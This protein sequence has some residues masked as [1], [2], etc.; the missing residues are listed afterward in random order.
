MATT[1]NYSFS[2]YSSTDTDVRFLDFRVATAGSQSTSNFYVIDTVLKQH[3]D[4]IDSIN[5]T[6]SAFVV[7][8]TYSSGSLYT[9]SVANYP[10]YK[11]EQLIVLSLNQKNTGAV[12]ININGTT[13]KD[14]M[15]Y[16]SDGVLKA[17]EAGDF[18]AN[19]PVLCLYDG[20]RFVVIGITSASSITVTGEAGDILQIADDGT[21]ESSG[22]KAAQPNGIATLDENGN[23]VQVA[24]MANSAAAVYSGEPVTVEY[25]DENRI[26]SVAVYGNN[27]QTSGTTTAPISMN[28]VDSIQVSGNNLFINNTETETKSG[29]TFTV[30]PNK[31]VTVNGTNSTS[32]SAV[33][34][35]GYNVSLPAGSYTL[36]GTSSL[37]GGAEIEIKIKRVSGAIE[38]FS[39]NNSLHTRTFN[40]ATG[41]IIDTFYVLVRAGQTADNVTVYP[42][43]NVGSTALPYEPYNGNITQLPI[44]REL[45]RIGEAA[46]K[47]ITRVKSVYDKRVVLD[48]SSDEVFIQANI[49]DGWIQIAT[50]SDAVIPE[51]LDIVGSIKSSYLN[52]YAID[53]I[54]LKKCSG[55]SVDSNRR[56][57]LSFKTSEY[58]DVTSVETAKTYLSAH[59][60][61]VYYQSTAYDGSNGL[62]VCLTEYQTGFVELDGETL[63]FTSATYNNTYW[64]L[65]SYSAPGIASNPHINSHFPS[66]VFE[67]NVKYSFIFSTK[68]KMEPYF[69]TVEALNAYLAAQKAAG[70]PVQIPYQLAT[71]EV[72][73]TDPVDF[74]NAAGPLTVVTGGQV[75]V[76]M[77]DFVT[78]RTPAFLNKLDKTGDGSDVTVTFTG[79]ATDTDIASGDKLSILFGKILKR[80]TNILNG[81]TKVG[82]ATKADTDNLGNQITGTYANSLGVANNTIVL[83][84]K[85][86][87][88]LSTI[89]VPYAN[90]AGNVAT[91]IKEMGIAVQTASPY[92]WF[93]NYTGS[94]NKDGARKYYASVYADNATYSTSAGRSN[95]IVI[96]N[97]NWS[98]TDGS[99]SAVYANAE[100][101]Y[102]NLS[103]SN[104]AGTAWPNI[105]VQ[106]INGHALNMA[107]NGTSLSITW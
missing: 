19:S 105:S 72:Y 6:P 107:L 16:G 41:D 67:S 68:T 44:P 25:V 91:S 60:L 79:A 43:L 78:D 28:G 31:S 14:V 71:P 90:S 24:N 15:K 61:T 18:V 34:Y 30:N 103:S 86:G 9:A 70:T 84:N 40:I 48:G 26:G 36:S 75:E 57:R 38:W 5:A 10:G 54:Y 17:V 21:I 74:D 49:I 3:S 35:T 62:D 65:P 96:Y 46:D 92:A 1:P 2:V 42:M 99:I 45:H 20:T 85:I 106:R 11:N 81:T 89:T 73:A 22:K 59:P 58:P 55:I 76:K 82:Y 13:N 63:A 100:K 77:T 47:C 32:A 33:H 7:K 98:G 80:F 97:N 94:G 50:E 102:V 56:I 12:Q 104:A 87:E 37:T 69:D 29:I 27:P 4:A 8:G 88:N 101:T 23:V 53:D 95:N 66:N 39:I 51:S 93:L 52:A 64:N 83:K